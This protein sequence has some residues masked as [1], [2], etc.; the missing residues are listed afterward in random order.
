MTHLDD[1]APGSAS[2][3][4]PRSWLHSDAPT[5]SL[6]GPW[7]FRLLP[8]APLDDEARVP[9]VADP[10]LD[11]ADWD[12]LPVPSHWVLHGH[13]S[14][15]YT[16]LQY[17]FPIDPP[18]VPD[19]NPTGE[20]RR[21]VVVP[22]S[23][24]SGAR[25]V[26][27]FDGVDGLA[28]VWLNGVELGWT[29]GSRLATEFDVTDALVEG[30]N[31]LAVRVNQWSAASYLEDQDQWWMPGIFRSVTLQSR[32][33]AALDDVDL[34]ASYDHATGA[35][36]LDLDVVGAFPVTLRVPALGVD[37]TWATP[38]DVA[39]V[40]LPA[41]EPWSAEVPRLYDATVA[42]PG[43]TVS[44]RVGFR[45][46]HIVGDSFEVN[47]RRVTFRG[48]NRH[49]SHPVRGRVFDEAE[50][51]ADLELMKRAHVNAIRTAH[52]PPHPRLLDLADE[53]GFWVVLEC[54]LETHGFWDVEWRGNP[55]DEPAWCDA[56]LDRIARTVERDKNHPSIVMWSLGNESGTG[57][58]LAAMATWLHGR[59]ATRPVHY[60]GDLAGE[61]TDVYS[62]MYPTLEEIASVCGEPATTIHETEGAQ[63]ARQ[64]QKPFVLC[65]YGHA[66]GNGPGSFADY[67]AAVDRW[68]S[69]HG[70]FVWEWRDH[71]IATRTPDGTP[72]FAYGGDFG[73]VVHDGQ[74]VMDGLLL[75]DGTPTPALAEFAA[76]IT[77]VRVRLLDAAR[78][79]TVENRRHTAST[80]DVEVRW[81]LEHDGHVVASGVLDVPTLTA[82]STATVEVPE[83]AR[84]AGDA[85]TVREAHLTVTAVTRHDL[86]W[87]GA[88]H[89]LGRDQALVASRP[90]ARTRASGAWSGDTLGALTFDARGALTSWHGLP[91]AGPRLELWRAPTDNDRGAGQGSYE[92]AEPELTHGR[93][94]EETPPS[95][96]RWVERGLHRLVHRVLS[97]CRS[98]HGLEQ[99]VRVS[100][101]HTGTGVD[102]TFRWTATADGVLLRTEAV[103]FGPWD[104]TWPRVGARFDLPLSLASSPVDWLGTGPAES[105]ADSAAAARVG[106]F[107]SSVDGLSVEYARPQETGH[108]PGLRSLTLGGPGGV[109]ASAGGPV[110]SVTTVPDGAGHRCGFQLARHT[111][112]QV[113]LAAHPHEL[114][115]PTALHLYLDDAQHGLGSRA[116]GPDVLP[117]HALW[118]SARAWEVVLA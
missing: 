1:V 57:R 24:R 32:P 30:A 118:P 14:P 68:P 46:V 115:E 53:Y 18:H 58:N 108:R 75:S 95:A 103:P 98:D 7:R 34:R 65:E 26:L 16:N 102:V 37:V 42:S 27:R 51:R 83:E 2:R 106:R 50:A 81:Q 79:V 89:V 43:E 80:D 72:Y 6:D 33:A 59:D 78:L 97:V 92:L 105:Y 47:G 85:A 100:A 49:E 94:A 41:V 9:E 91:V 88:G 28:T 5:H 20:Y 56:Y 55:S 96:E 39:P 93:G 60:E 117:R 74:F 62:R 87:A 12:E 109:A 84:A 25:V 4:A 67:E 77:P 113:A 104:C 15:I 52:Y 99:R 66:M 110:L 17:P 111:A 3:L 8:E 70:G 76:V 44:L 90:A 10:E 13:G 64:R 73:E 54:D 69:L 29:T 107:T 86:P 19:E 63:G 23:F 45:T 40:D 101:A 31:A 21:T 38:A 61:Y 82:Q 22:A 112:Q 48:V 11:D 114:P 71:G 35:G 36:R 116:C